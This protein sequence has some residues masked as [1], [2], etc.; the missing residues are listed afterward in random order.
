MPDAKTLIKELK[1]GIESFSSDAKAEKVGTV[2][3]VGDGIARMT[4]LADCLS[5]EM[6]EFPGGIYGVALNLGRR[7]GRRHD[8]GRCNKNQRR[9]HGQADRQNSFRSGRRRAC[10]PRC[11]SVGTARLTAKGEIKAAAQ[12]PVEKIAP[13][14]L[15][16]EARQYAASDR[17]KGDRRHDPDRPRTAR[18]DH[19]RPANRQNRHGR[20]RH[21]Q[22]KRQGRHLHLRGHRAK[23]IESSAHRGQARRN[24]RHGAHHRRCRRRQLGRRFAIHRAVRRLRPW[25]NISWT[26]AKTRSWFTTIFPSTPGLT[27]KCRSSCAVRPDAKRIPGDVFYLHSR[28]LERAARMSKKERRRLAD[29]LADH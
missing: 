11:R 7:N 28:L 21:H 5:A 19:R 16:R 18:T 13:G 23:G 12:Y 15:A 27:A 4:G 10:R 2:I 22:P 24:R 8:P 17:N 6:F 20:G 26:R 14:V 9:R 1:D 3:E 25:A 29:R